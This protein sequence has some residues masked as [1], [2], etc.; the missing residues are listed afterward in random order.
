L[1]FLNNDI[2]IITPD[3]IEEMLMY[4]QR[5]DVGV[6]GIKLLF[7]NG[8]VQHAGVILGMG[9]IGGHVYLGAPRDALGYMTRLQIVQNLSAVSAACIMIKRSV[10]EE[11]G[12]FNPEFSDSFNDIDLCLK[13][14]KAGYLIVWTPYAEAY[15]LESK[16]RG[17]NTSS[18]KKRLLA[19][20]TALFKTK[21]EKELDSGDPYYNCNFSLNRADY[22]LR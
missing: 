5:S 14:R 15:H 12:L 18:D 10:F 16:T 4:S 6:V 2:V 9:G 17:Y 22:S 11:A 1:V 19:Q 20:E 13:V 21:W 3:W 7:L 8:T